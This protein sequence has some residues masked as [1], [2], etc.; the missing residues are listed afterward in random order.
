MTGPATD[1]PAGAG[2][3]ARPPHPVRLALRQLRYEQLAFWRNPYG[4]VFT[5]GFSVVFLVLESASGATA[6]LHRYGGI[7]A[8]QYYVAGFAAYGVMSACFNTLALQLVFRRETGL[9]K[10]LR[11][12]PLPPGAMVASLALHTLVVSAID[13]VLVTVVGAAAYHAHLP[14]DPLPMLVTLLVGVAAF[15]S[16]GVAAS[17]L[18]PNQDAAGPMIGIVFFV[19]LFL[20]GLWFPLQRGTTLY[21]I[22]RWFPIGHFITAVFA[23]LQLRPGVSAWD[24]KDLAWVAGWGMAGALLAVRRFRWEPRRH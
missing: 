8:V 3:G 9:L 22:S 19:L 15:T 17:T 1:M 20:S 21:A 18:V 5:A 2:R 7:H 4:A 10:R 14:A 11:L 16:L 6:E 24:P 13:V 12:S 23:P